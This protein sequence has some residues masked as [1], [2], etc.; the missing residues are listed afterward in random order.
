MASL[1]AG[2]ASLR[3]HHHDGPHRSPWSAAAVNSAALTATTPTAPKR[4]AETRS[5]EWVRDPE[6]HADRLGRL[7]RGRVATPARRAAPAIT[8]GCQIPRP[9]G[10]GTPS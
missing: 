9:D 7:P 2:A 4:C 10:V 3:N 6:P 5:A 1:A 8:D